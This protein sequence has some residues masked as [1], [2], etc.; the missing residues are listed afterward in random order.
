VAAVEERLAG[1][2]RQRPAPLAPQRGE[3]RVAVVLPE[4]VEDNAEAEAVAEA[5]S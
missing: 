4:P 1:M 3:T 2:P 5:C